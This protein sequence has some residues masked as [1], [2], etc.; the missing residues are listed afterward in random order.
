MFYRN[1]E[2]MLNDSREGE[3]QNKNMCIFDDHAY[4]HGHVYHLN[5][6]CFKGFYLH[7]VQF[8]KDPVYGCKRPFHN[9]VVSCKTS[10]LYNVFS[11][12]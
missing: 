2:F 7:R 1:K 12:T 4:K 5:E 11:S 9:F 10:M 6:I 3:K 8:G